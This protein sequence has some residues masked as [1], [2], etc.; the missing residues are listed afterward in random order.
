MLNSI[1]PLK[2]AEV[3]SKVNKRNRIA[4]S[5]YEVQLEERQDIITNLSDAAFML[6]QYYLRC[7]SID[8]TPMEDDDAALYF[9]WSIRKV[10]RARK[11]LENEGYF[12]KVVYSSSAGKKAITYYIS[13]ERVSEL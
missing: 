1:L 4:H 5:K 12:K 7:A 6:Y 9:G 2:N 8:D 11:Q 13:K 10:A 3:N